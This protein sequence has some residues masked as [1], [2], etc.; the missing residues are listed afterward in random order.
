L[1]GAG[2]EA[3]PERPVAT[4]PEV[5]AI[6]AS[7][8]PRYRLLVLL[9]AFAQLRFGELLGLQRDDLTVP[10]QRKPTPD[11]IANCTDPNMLIDDGVPLLRVDRAITPT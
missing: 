3:S 2:Q 4:L 5:F 10:K 7:I 8:Q 9:A 1:T 6:A 11:E